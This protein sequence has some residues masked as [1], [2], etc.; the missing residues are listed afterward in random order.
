MTLEEWEKLY[1]ESC[2]GCAAISYFYHNE[3]SYADADPDTLFI[4]LGCPFVYDGYARLCPCPECLIKMI[5]ENACPE[6]DKQF[7][8]MHELVDGHYRELK[9][10]IREGEDIDD[11][12]KRLGITDDD[13]EWI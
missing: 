2:V 3:P 9:E 12:F 13:G 11:A 7:E 5:C 4:D 10:N 8:V 1:P 6:K